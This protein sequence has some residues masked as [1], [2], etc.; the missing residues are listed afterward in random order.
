MGNIT[1]NE[2]VPPPPA[3]KAKTNESTPAL[4][5]LLAESTRANPPKAKEVRRVDYTPLSYKVSKVSLEF[6]LF[7]RRTVVDSVLTVEKNDTSGDSGALDSNGSNDTV[8]GLDLDG[9]EAVVSLLKLSVDGCG[10]A[11]VP[12]VDYILQPGKLFIKAETLQKGASNSNGKMIVRS[13]VEIVPEDNT[14]LSGLYKD[15]SGMFCSQC[16][17]QGFRRITYY[18]D[19]PDNMATFERVRI[20]AKAN[21]FPVLLSNGNLVEEGKCDG[22]EGRK[23][24]IWS[25]PFPKPSYLFALVAGDLGSIHDTFT[26]IS[27]R[28]VDLRFYSEVSY[29]M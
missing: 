4:N 23:Y 12:N 5:A 13:T 29:C 21:D 1:D 6:N 11:L 25:D 3:K 14:L 26:T 20:E 18:P 27:G 19:R 2:P 17:A 15:G 7:E 9:D 24:A 22:D 8:D 10:D 16:E 28:K